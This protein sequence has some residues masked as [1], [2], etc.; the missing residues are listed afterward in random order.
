MKKSVTL[1][2]QVAA[3]YI[4]TVVG[5]GFATGREIVAFFT[6]Y[7]HE[8][9]ISILLCTWLLTWLGMKVMLVGSRLR[10]TS[11]QQV[12]N[13]LFGSFF[14]SLFNGMMFLTLVGVTSVMIS[15]AGAIFEEQL[16]VSSQVGILLTIALTVFTLRFGVKGI[17]SV[18]MIVVPI[19]IVFSFILSIHTLPFYSAS[20]SE[21]LSLSPSSI[22][23]SILYASFNLALAQAVLVPL[24]TEV[25]DEKA[26]KIGA[27][28]GGVGLGVILLAS[29][30][31]LLSLHN[32]EL[33]DI[34]M[35]EIMKEGLS[36]FYYLYLLVMCGEVFTSVIGNV[37]GIERQMKSVLKRS[38]LV[39]MTI[40]VVITYSVSLIG[41]SDLIT[42]LYPI[43]GYLSVVFLVL[44]AMKKIPHN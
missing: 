14:G 43:F 27:M 21:M 34:P 29:H 18:N 3:I 11:Y 8:A 42:R 1:G 31:A 22:V 7:S 36:H 40:I 15:G 19:F 24:A 13:Y 35:A 26:I 2:I 30:L 23:S 39:N 17:S 37:Y 6:K 33:Y 25:N 20:M 10:A 12:S 44:L 28:L 4:G 5:A 41:Y 16:K 38:K 32:V 9:F